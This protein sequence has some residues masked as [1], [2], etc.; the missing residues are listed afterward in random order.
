MYVRMY[1]G[2]VELL[3]R[4]VATMPLRDAA[5]CGL[6][7]VRTGSRLITKARNCRFRRA[8]VSNWDPRKQHENGMQTAKKK[9][10][11]RQIAGESPADLK[12][13]NEISWMAVPLRIP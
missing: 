3:T 5:L 12:R 2:T 13:R 6:L 4:V 11:D 7:V 9:K 1:A 10:I 8:S